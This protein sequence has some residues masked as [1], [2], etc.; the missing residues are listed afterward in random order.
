MT[1]PPDLV[2]DRL[3]LTLLDEST[4]AAV[5]MLLFGTAIWRQPLPLE[6]STRIDLT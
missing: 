6:A 1:S 3:R 5:L 2:T 4:A